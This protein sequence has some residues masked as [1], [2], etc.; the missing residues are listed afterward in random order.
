MVRWVPRYRKLRGSEGLGGGEGWYLMVPNSLHP[1]CPDSLCS[2][3]NGWGEQLVEQSCA[4][5]TGFSCRE[6]NVL[7][8]LSHWHVMQKIWLRGQNNRFGVIALA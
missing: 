6:K 7:Y 4:F 8:Y 1:L 5:V 3:R 2:E